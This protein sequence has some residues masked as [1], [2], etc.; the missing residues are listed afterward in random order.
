MRKLLSFIPPGAFPADLTSKVKFA[1]K[2]T[3]LKSSIMDF[4]IN[5]SEKS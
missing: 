4:Y 5:N 2:Y 3:D 1:K